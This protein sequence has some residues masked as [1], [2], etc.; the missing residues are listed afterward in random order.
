LKWFEK[1]V[2]ASI[3][4]KFAVTGKCFGLEI[5]M[6][7]NGKKWTKNFPEETWK[8]DK[9]EGSIDPS[10]ME[11]V[12][13]HPS[14]DEVLMKD[15]EELAKLYPESEILNS[16]R[17][18][19]HIHIN[20]SDMKIRELFSFLTLYYMME[21]NILR[22]CGASRKGNFFC[23]T[24]EEAPIYRYWLEEAIARQDLRT[25]DVNG[26]FRYVAMNLHSISKFGSI[27]FR[28]IQTPSDLNKINHWI[29]MFSNM[30]DV[31]KLYDNPVDWIE[32]YSLHGPD[33]ILEKLNWKSDEV[34]RDLLQTGVWQIQPT[35]FRIEWK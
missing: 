33:F 19:V 32:G 29:R 20:V 25:I 24:L 12:Y 30:I 8:I 28:G 22:E 10:G 16:P 9:D 34:T 21:E 35:I 7:P 3:G 6:E 4:R 2:E 31:S 15:V 23:L 14:S 26:E 1:T 5:E 11:L 17:T 13:R 27:E 18:G